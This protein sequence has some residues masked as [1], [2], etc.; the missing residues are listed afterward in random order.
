MGNV[1]VSNYSS[2]LKDYQRF[3]ST[4]YSKLDVN[5]NCTSTGQDSLILDIGVTPLGNTCET[6][7]SGSTINA[8][9]SVSTKCT[10]LSKT[11]AEVTSTV[12]S[13]V[14]ENVLKFLNQAQKS[15]QGWLALGFSAQIENA[16]TTTEL[17]TTITDAVSSQ[18]SEVCDSTA[19]SYINKIVTLCG[20]YT[21]DTINL[22]EQA[23]STA[24]MSCTT[25]LMVKS[26]QNNA[27]LTK[28]ASKAFQGQASTQ[29]GIFSGLGMLIIGA[30]I[31]VVL[32][33][34]IGGGIYLLS[35]SGDSKKKEQSQQQE[36]LMMMENNMGNNNY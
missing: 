19:E 15:K 10:G 25:D 27:T 32:I 31:L 3:T 36:Q 23:I 24:Y 34:L 12:K 7:V 13:T 29:S 30:I 20:I 33:L 17:A 26:W 2:V 14:N 35:G 5:N 11:S 6:D 8:G 16:S 9:Q 22:N 4:T 18:V 21:N 1:Q 28:F